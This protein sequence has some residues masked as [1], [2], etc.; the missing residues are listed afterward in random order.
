[1]ASK[2]TVV[3]AAG[4]LLRASGLAGVSTPVVMPSVSEF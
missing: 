4:V 1:V 3:L 2:L